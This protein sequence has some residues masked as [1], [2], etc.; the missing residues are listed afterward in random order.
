MTQDL[1]RHTL[2]KKLLYPPYYPEF[3]PSD[4]YLFGKRKSALIGR[5][6]RDEIDLLELIAE[7][8]NDIS[9]TRL[10]RVFRNWIERVEG[11]LTQGIISPS[12]CAH[13]PC[14]ILD[15]VLYG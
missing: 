12:Q 10:Q 8:L 5:E 1:F 15:R 11:R 13:L 6:I 2:L 7:I 4:F 14:F 3:S 9:D